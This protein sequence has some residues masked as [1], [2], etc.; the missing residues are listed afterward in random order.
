MKLEKI[1]EKIKSRRIIF[2]I[3]ILFLMAVI[4]SYIGP[5]SGDGCWHIFVGKYISQTNTIPFDQPLGRGGFFH[6]PFLFHLAVAL[7]YKISDGINFNIIFLLLPLAYLGSLIF[8]YHMI[9]EEFGEKISFW[10][11][12]F[13]GTAPIFLDY[14]S[15]YFI[16]IFLTFFVIG[17]VYFAKKNR[18]FL[19]GLFFGMAIFSKSNGWFI[20]PCLIYIIYKLNGVKSLKK[21]LWFIVPGLVGII[22]YI[23]NYFLFNNPFWPF[24]NSIF[25]GIN[26]SVPEGIRILKFNF[27]L[28]SVLKSSFLS[29][30]G[31]PHGA[32]ENSLKIAQSVTGFFSPEIVYFFL[33]SEIIIVLIFL[34]FGLK[35]M[36]N[37]KS[38]E[39]STQFFFG[40]DSSDMTH[41]EKKET[42]EE[43]KKINLET[44]KKSYL[45]W[46]LGFLFLLAI[47]IINAGITELRL[48][49]PC[50]PVIA[51][52]LGLGADYSLQKYGQ[53]K[54]IIVFILLC[55]VVI[56]M[57][58]VALK[59]FIAS[60][61]W[62]NFES[63]FNFI[64]ENTSSE[65]VFYYN[66][67]CFSIRTN[68]FSTSIPE[69][70]SKIKP[71]RILFF[72]DNYYVEPQASL[73][74]E[75][76]TKLKEKTDCK[77]IYDNKNTGTKL[78]LIN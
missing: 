30:L 25:K 54:K 40:K 66:G 4:L 33:L 48:I 47:Y 69:N 77:I 57:T 67:Q 2:L 60:E 52:L 39:F 74:L 73:S 55:L 75:E 14:A 6:P 41:D 5:I 13:L 34:F 61:S 45:L 37:L 65:T 72:N 10:S 7:F 71:V 44:I 38:T 18:L 78:C 21:W 32:I 49:L 29:F 68:R 53:Y 70:D 58:T 35:R 46:V 8:F 17:A 51:L 64:E 11:I 12:L 23:R 20:L 9:R 56:F 22:P 28:I 76:Q 24:L 31:V 1:K 16:E 27:N 36:I 26:E 62:N 3:S 43:L 42:K 50:Y 59:H 15:N 19:S 63:D